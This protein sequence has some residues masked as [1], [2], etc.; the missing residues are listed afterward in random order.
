MSLILHSHPF[1]AF[2]QK[3][4]IALYELE[5][6]FEARLVEGDEGRQELARLW[7]L[8]GMPVLVDEEAGATVVE[9]TIVIEYV[10]QLAT[11]G[12]RG[13]SPRHLIPADPR[14]ALDARL[15]ERVADQYL[16]SVMQKIVLDQLRPES[17]RDAY[18]VAE[19]RR[20]AATAYDVLDAQLAGNAWAVGAAFT[21]ADCAML[22]P[23]FYLWAIHRWDVERHADVTRYY[24]A[25]LARPSVARVLEEARPYRDNFPLPWPEDQDVL[26]G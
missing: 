7:P 15:W 22:P 17:E 9:S 8:A 19:A 4:L 13:G 12:G 25:L 1:A 16:A 21:I 5:L 2:C 20:R 23:L 3:A 14:A 26:A 6:P 10:D 11:G 18:G 24:R